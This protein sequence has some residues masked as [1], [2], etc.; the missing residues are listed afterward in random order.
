MIRS[1]TVAPSFRS[2]AST[3]L[4]VPTTRR[5]SY[6]APRR[7]G[8]LV[9]MYGMFHDTSSIPNVC[10]AYAHAL[11]SLDS[12]LALHSYT[13]GSDRAFQ[14][15]SLSPL[16]GIDESAPVAFYYGLPEAVLGPAR[17]HD[18]RIIGLACETDRIPPAWVSCINTF[19]LAVVPSQYCRRSLIDSGVRVPVA[20]V[21]HG[22]EPCYRPTRQQQR[23]SP[24][25][26][27]NVVNSQM[28]G[29]KG[30]APLLRAFRRAFADRSDVILRLRLQNSF[31]V[32]E[33]FAAAKVSMDDVQVEIASEIDLPAEEFAAHYS[34][35]HC[36]VHPSLSEGFG[37]I[38]FQSIACETPVI[39]PRST[40]LAEYIDE[41]N[42][43]VLRNDGICEAPEV[44]YRTGTCPDIDEDHLVEL[45][46]HA[47]ANWEHEYARVRAVAPAFRAQH[48]WEKAL[49]RFVSLVEELVTLPDPAD[50]RALI[51]E[52]VSA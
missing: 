23:S 36:T 4:D 14:D 9:Q 44:Y 39:A 7:Q 22:L 27:Y 47:E 10:A 13:G 6:S 8:A 52:R 15:P 1:E 17:G 46:R 19:D 48:T 24:F 42:A 45:L 34:E 12:R 40:G 31:P 28:P 37:L 20:V 26:F 49:A 21:R 51:R 2:V 32:R 25:V 29:R 30:L 18:T 5:Y 3:I 50:R 35:V 41:T 38:P 33:C 11:S 43:M 16:A